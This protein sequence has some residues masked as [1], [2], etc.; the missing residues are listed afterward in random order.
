LSITQ[1]LLLVSH[2]DPLPQLFEQVPPHPLSPPHFPEQD[3]VQQFPL[4]H[5]P[6]VPQRVPLAASRNEQAPLL[7]HEPTLQAAASPG[8]S[9]LLRHSTHSASTHICEPEHDPQVP[10]HPSSPH[11]LPLH[12]GVH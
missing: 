4:L 1:V 3:G 11:S 2:L 5:V 8:Q 12:C 9:L 6:L 10:L 7:L